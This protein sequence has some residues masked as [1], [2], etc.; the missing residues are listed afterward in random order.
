[1]HAHKWIAKQWVPFR[2]M[3]CKNNHS[4]VKKKIIYRVNEDAGLRV[5]VC[6][7]VVV[8][9]ELDLVPLSLL[10]AQRVRG[11]R[12][13]LAGTHGEGVGGVSD[14]R[15]VA[16]DRKTGTKNEKKVQNNVKNR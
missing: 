6:G 14:S 15:V 5:R 16:S 8:H 9:C 11:H 1:M 13:P 3:D 12:V 7:V 4:L 10:Q 2:E